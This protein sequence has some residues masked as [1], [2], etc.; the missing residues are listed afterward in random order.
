MTNNGGQRRLA[1]KRLAAMP[2]VLRVWDTR[3]IYRYPSAKCSCTSVALPF[4]RPRTSTDRRPKQYCMYAK[5][6][7]LKMMLPIPHELA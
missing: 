2:P 6:V 4:S 7:E 1:L 5:R 3:V